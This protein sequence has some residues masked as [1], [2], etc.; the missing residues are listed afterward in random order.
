MTDDASQIADRRR[1]W[2]QLTP[3]QQMQR[4]RYAVLD[5]QDYAVSR[6]QQARRETAARLRAQR[7]KEGKWTL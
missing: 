7:M 2:Q 4:V 1:Q 6:R 3:Q 5:F